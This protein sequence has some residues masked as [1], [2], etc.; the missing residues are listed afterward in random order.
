MLV[1]GTNLMDGWI[2]EVTK[3]WVHPSVGYCCDGY[4]VRAEHG[5]SH[6]HQSQQT[7]EQCSSLVT[8]GSSGHVDSPG[9]S[10]SGHWTGQS[11]EHQQPKLKTRPTWHLLGFKWT[12][13]WES[14]IKILI[15]CNI[16]FYLFNIY[17]ICLCSGHY[18]GGGLWVEPLWQDM[19]CVIRL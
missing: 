6:P 7:T 17:Q 13:I 10:I 9:P 19:K 8:P 15:L 14:Y 2:G 16:Y 11:Q 4:L 3:V 18:L 12:Y 5:A 1:T